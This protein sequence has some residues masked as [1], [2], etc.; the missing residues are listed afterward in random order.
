MYQQGLFFSLRTSRL[1]PLAWN[2]TP[3][4]ALIFLYWE[5]IFPS[6]R[7]NYKYFKGAMSQGN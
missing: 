1:F 3:S 4:F 7:V 6:I 5:V 2:V